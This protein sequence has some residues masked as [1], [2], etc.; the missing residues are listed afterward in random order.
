MTAEHTSKE[1]ERNRNRI[2]SG[3][4]M[5]E[6]ELKTV[7][8]II[9]AE[10][11]KTD[12]EIAVAVIPESSDYAAFELLFAVVLGAAV[13]AAL[14]LFHQKIE[15]ALSAAFWLPSRALTTGVMGLVSFGSIALFFQLLN[16]PA[17]DRIIVPSAVRN[18]AVRRRA[19]RRFV[20]GGVYATERRTGILLF[21]SLAE[22]RIEIVADTGI[23]EQIEQS[24]WDA[25]AAGI[26][27]GARQGK[28]AEALTEAVTR[29]GTL[30]ASRF[31]PKQH[32]PNEL[33]DRVVLLE[34]GS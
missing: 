23:A 17:I 34:A 27:E 15:D 3:L 8:Q 13:F 2:L 18:T 25:I 16:R 32:N 31:P 12:G 10:E 4:K 9:E 14:M 7:E 29:C 28:T 21:L 22:R 24:E 5:N 26:A 1:S 33:A 11:R 6:S 20:E 19:V 30:L